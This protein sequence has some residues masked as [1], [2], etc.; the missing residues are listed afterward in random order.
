MKKPIVLRLKGTMV[1]EAKKLIE[2]SGFNMI[3]TEDLDDAAEKAVK[4]A[5][6]LKMA[7]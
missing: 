2:E 3:F 5:A 4:M 7:R 6:I 1:D